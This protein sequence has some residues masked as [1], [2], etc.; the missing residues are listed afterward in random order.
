MFSDRD[1]FKKIICI[2]SSKLEGI[3]DFPGI[4]DED[5]ISE[6]EIT[7]VEKWIGFKYQDAS[8]KMEITYRIWS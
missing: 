6:E 2:I 8:R 4:I 3:T 1:K 7:E 5:D